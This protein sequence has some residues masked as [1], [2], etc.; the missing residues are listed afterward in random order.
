MATIVR[1]IFEGQT[2]DLDV[3]EDIPLR[4]DMSAVENTEIGEFYG[5]GSQTFVLPGTKRNNRFFNH[6]YQIGVS[7]IPGFYNTVD[8]YIIQDGETL[9]QGQL[10]L[11]E[12]IT[13]E[14]GKYTDYKIQVSDSVVQFKDKIAGTL[15]ADLDW[16]AYDHTL[17]KENIVSSWTDGVVSGS[18][19]YPMADYGKDEYTRDV[20]G[21]PNIILQP[22][23]SNR[24]GYINGTFTPMNV[25][26]FLPSIK[27]KDVLDVIFEQNGFRYTG[28]FVN[29]DDF[30]N[31]YVLP[32]SRQGLGP[33]GGIENTTN[34]V[35]GSDQVVAGVTPT[36][37]PSEAVVQF[38]QE[39]SDPG[40]NYSTTLF[41]YV[42]PEAGKYKFDAAI[43]PINPATLNADVRVSL[44]IY[45]NNGVT[46]ILQAS[47]SI[48][49]SLLNPGVYI[50]LQVSDETDTLAGDIFKVKVRL[51]HIGGSG[52]SNNLT[53]QSF[54]VNYFNTSIAPTS[55]EGVN[56]DFSEQWD[57]STK[58]L[59]FIKGLIEEFNLI[60][61]PDPIQKNLIH[62]EKF[63]DWVSNGE[64]KDWTDIWNTAENISMVHTVAEQ[65]KEILIANA[66]D[67][68]RFS[69]LSLETFPNYQYGTQRV[70]ADNTVSQGERKIGS[71]FAPVVLGSII[72]PSDPNQAGTSETVFNLDEGNTFI[73][74]HLYK[75]ENSKQEAFK[76]KPRIGYKNTIPINESQNFYVGLKDDLITVSGSYATISN[77][78]DL[79]AT[80]S[81]T[82]DLHFNNEYAKLIPSSYN[83]TLGTDN[84]ANYWELYIN[85]LYW[86]GA[87]KVTL[88]VKFNSDDYKNIKLNDQIFIK[89]QRYRIN[90]IKGFNVTQDDV[91][92]VELLRLYPSYYALDCNFDYTIETTTTPTPTPTETGIPTPTPTITPVVPT[93]TPT[94]TTSPTATPTP[95]ISPTP[96]TSPTPTISPTPTPT[97]TTSP[98][99]TPTPTTTPT[100]TPCPTY[101]PTPTPTPT[102]A[103]PTPTP[104]QTPTPTPT[105]AFG[106][107]GT[108]CVYPFA[109][110]RFIVATSSVDLGKT[111]LVDFG[112]DRRDYACYTLCET[113][114]IDP[115]C[116][117]PIVSVYD[118]CQTCLSLEPPYPTPTPTPTAT[119]PPGSGYSIYTGSLEAWWDGTDKN[120]YWTNN[121]SQYFWSSSVTLLS[122]GGT[123]LS[124][125]NLV[126]ERNMDCGDFYDFAVRFQ[127]YPTQ[128]AAAGLDIAD[129]ARF[130]NGVT[131][132]TWIR[133]LNPV[134]DY[135]PNPYIFVGKSR[136]NQKGEGYYLERV[137]G[138]KEMQFRSVEKGTSFP[139]PIVSQS[140]AGGFIDERS[141]F[142]HYALVFQNGTTG[143]YNSKDMLFYV[144]GELIS[145]SSFNEDVPGTNPTPNW[146]LII[147]RNGDDFNNPSRWQ[148]ID[149]G[150]VR[151]YS[152]PLSGSDIQ[153]N[154]ISEYWKYHL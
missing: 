44:G 124:A 2:Y 52:A 92:T 72:K 5:I 154:Y 109:D 76:F 17:T 111:V 99:A 24:N 60:L 43:T 54:F 71:F 126:F 125:Q 95:T 14:K 34:I 80:A 12:I 145:S 134:T 105:L 57:S 127:G 122:G 135:N 121:G 94:P 11:L 75:F 36:G 39:N 138:S 20:F 23:G 63:N 146:D 56:V 41:E 85:S 51:D 128:E 73:L 153:N 74:P 77:F 7:N 110:S 84:F 123:P 9:L 93:P 136:G 79:P 26:Q 117:F 89:N 151:L 83:P 53:I 143:P 1:A 27:I 88:D 133:T 31:L 152:T 91:A 8:A 142:Q 149:V 114:S 82:N 69:K 13:S 45:Y 18:I 22:S 37:G 81:L 68:D 98:T 137:F 15:L 16:S 67:N 29:T 42:T 33:G 118:N 40:N 139:Y 55:Y 101:S 144:N 59:D 46:D 49:C 130:T 21:I 64:K 38:N 58:S 129:R 90:K 10:Q 102:G 62:I 28:D 35:M 97:P 25:K 150:Q 116:Q 131:I 132:E 115:M 120:N 50:P 78:S 106:Y 47:Q 19:F 61:Y 112:S 96:T 30:S 87:Q 86:E 4:I 107:L 103:T 65:P 141:E 70:I 147:A 66:D 100:A 108:S 148:K 32:K 3:R 119:E 6:A 104:T 140:I 48:D 113:A